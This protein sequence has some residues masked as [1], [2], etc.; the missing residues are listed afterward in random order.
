MERPA[1]PV[2]YQCL[3][4]DLIYLCENYY[5]DQ[6]EEFERYE[7]HNNT[8]DNTG[9]VSFL[10]NFLKVAE[11]DQLKYA[12]K[13]LDFG[14]GPGP[15]LKTLLNRL[16]MEVD[17]YDQYFFPD[18]NFKKTTYDLITCTEV[19]EHLKAPMETLS[20]LESLLAENGILAIKTL[21][22]PASADFSGWW[23]RKDP[24][25]IC[26]YSPLTFK[27]IE[28]NFNLK[29]KLIDNHSICVL[30]KC[31]TYTN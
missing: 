5:L 27:W 6:T 23:Y 3:Y 15:V 24:T 9:Y 17:I 25:H 14:C 16:N 29:I 31:L 26:F 19:F 7:K 10:T 13:A 20:L 28:N 30:Q 11:I 1:S 18:N 8:L 2:Y 22:H 12:N 4:C 21:F